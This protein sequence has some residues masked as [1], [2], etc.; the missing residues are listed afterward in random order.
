MMLGMPVRCSVNPR[1]GRE[2]R[3][4]GSLPPI[5]RLVQVPAEQA[6]LGLTGSKW[7]MDLVGLVMKKRKRAEAPGS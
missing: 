1:T 4:P 2:S 6:L 7:F 3:R 5:K